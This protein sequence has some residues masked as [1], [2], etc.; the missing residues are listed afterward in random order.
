MAIWCACAQRR[1]EPARGH[2]HD[3]EAAASF[4]LSEPCP[5]HHEEAALPG[6]RL[7]RCR[8]PGEDRQSGSATLPPGP[9]GRT[10]RRQDERAAQPR[11]SPAGRS[12]QRPAGRVPGSRVIGAPMRRSYA[13]RPLLV[14]CSTHIVCVSPTVVAALPSSAAKRAAFGV[15]SP[16]S[17]M[18][19]P[20]L[21]V[22]ACWSSPRTCSAS[23][24]ADWWA[25]ALRSS[26]T[27]RVVTTKPAT[28]NK[29]TKSDTAT[30]AVATVWS[31]RRQPV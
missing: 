9:A 16:L 21:N 12:R 15:G 25:A 6:D 17:T 23:L 10:R 19:S 3:E 31:Q 30:P 20:M 27:R 1:I 22:S 26:S 24:S 7:G 14:T 2:E 13:R 4:A 29:R 18:A 28:L 5:L 11:T 8:G